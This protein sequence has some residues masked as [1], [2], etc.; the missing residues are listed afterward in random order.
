MFCKIVSVCY[1]PERK[2]WRCVCWSHCTEIEQQMLDK[3]EYESFLMSSFGDCCG[4]G[5]EWT[6][7][8]S[9]VRSHFVVQDVE[10]VR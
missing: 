1:V 7:W 3:V 4:L 9:C 8:N 10:C 6:W 2:W 5:G